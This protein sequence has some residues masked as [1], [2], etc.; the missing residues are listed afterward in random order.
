MEPMRPAAAIFGSVYNVRN[1]FSRLGMMLSQPS[2]STGLVHAQLP[3]FC[4]LGALTVAMFEVAQLIQNT[5]QVIG[6]SLVDT[7]GACRTQR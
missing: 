3:S 1:A 2:C 4:Q 7:K 6:Y 5:S